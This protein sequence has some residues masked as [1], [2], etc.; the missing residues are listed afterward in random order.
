MQI[1]QRV[2]AILVTK[3][4]QLILMKRMKEGFAPHW[5]APGGGLVD[6]DTSLEAALSREIRAELGGTVTVVKPV[7]FLEHILEEEVVIKQWFY[8]CYLLDYD[9]DS[10]SSA[11]FNG[12]SWGEYQIETLPLKRE[13]L[14]PLN[15]QPE[16]L[17]GFLLSNCD[18]LMALPA[19]RV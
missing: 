9:L 12:V 6:S 2:R 10:R 17:K 13:V 3:N 19:I 7:F 1:S 16:K 11:D 8:L 5:V 18:H 15:I 14:K 4:N